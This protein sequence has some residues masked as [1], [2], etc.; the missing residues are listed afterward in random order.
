MNGVPSVERRLIL[1]LTG[2]AAVAVVGVLAILPYRLYQRDIRTAEVNAHRIAGVVHASI[3][4]AIAEGEDVADVV[5]R[6]QGI[7]ATEITLERLDEGEVHPAATA[8]RG[9][10]V[11]RGTDL[12]Y[13]APPILDRNGKT[14]IA[15]MYF[16]LTPMKRNS[17]RLIV[18][19]VVAVMVG[20]LCFSLA[21][22]F[23]I[24]R[25]L[26]APLR[27]I[28]ET[29]ER[30]AETGEPVDVPEFRTREMVDLA[31]AI[32]R[33]QGAIG[34]RDAAREDRPGGTR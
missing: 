17:V 30:V 5:N 33:A 18:G 28:T 11:L 26:V 3:S 25:S 31:R 23:L 14:M 15:S 13:Y 2:I 7:A 24:R 12:T 1:L 34:R 21:V 20:S 32:Q 8:L 9:S 4:R 27:R 6:F 10:S 19:L 16:D 29:F 22:F